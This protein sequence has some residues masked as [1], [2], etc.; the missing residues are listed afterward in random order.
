M[1]NMNIWEGEFKTFLEATRK[2]KGKDLAE[3]V[4]GLTIK[5]F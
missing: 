5:R 4:E 2:S 3:K 1:N